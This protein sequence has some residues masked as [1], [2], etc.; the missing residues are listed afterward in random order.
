[1]GR[2]SSVRN[3]YAPP[4]S[5]GRGLFL[6]LALSSALATACSVRKLAVGSLASTIGGSADV[7]ASDD[8]PELVR[9]ALPFAL[10]TIESLILQLPIEIMKL[11]TTLAK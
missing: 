8:D 7:F 2:F 4:G 5:V 1:M 11:T 10:K 3:P 6:A 9:D